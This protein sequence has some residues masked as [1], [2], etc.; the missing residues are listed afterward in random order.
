MTRCSHGIAAAAVVLLASPNGGLGGPRA[1]TEPRGSKIVLKRIDELRRADV[2]A[3][4]DSA[5]IIDKPGL[6]L[7]FAIELPEGRRLVDVKEPGSLVAVDST[8]RDLTAVDKNMFGRREYVEVIRVWGKGPKA[9]ELNLALPDRRATTFDLDT[10]LEVV[11]DRGSR[12]AVVEVGPDWTPLDA[13]LF[14]GRKVS[15]R[16][17]QGRNGIQLEFRPGTIRASIEKLQL[18]GEGE[19]LDSYSSMWNDAQI[20][21]SFQGKYEEGMNARL[22]LRKGLE[23]TAM[24]IDLQAQPLP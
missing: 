1:P 22:T 20:A 16:L 19:P 13:E 18:L 2:T 21:Y 24:A 8:G 15:A 3:A 9:F 11:T 10:T 7:R 6:E 12:E 5:F 4:D 17:K 14:C 23:T